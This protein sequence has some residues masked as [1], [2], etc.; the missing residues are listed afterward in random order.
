MLDF[1]KPALHGTRPRILGF[2]DSN[3]VDPADFLSIESTLDSKIFG[4]SEEERG[5]H[6]ANVVKPKEIVAFYVRSMLKR[7]TALSI[8]LRLVD[9]P[10][11]LKKQ[12]EDVATT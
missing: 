4:L 2:L 8:K 7:D 3:N 6:L 10:G 5:R 12:F 9:Q 11:L 1:Y